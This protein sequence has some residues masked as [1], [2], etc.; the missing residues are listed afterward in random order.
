MTYTYA[1]LKND[2][3]DLNESQ[4]TMPVYIIQNNDE[5]YISGELKFCSLIHSFED[6]Y[7]YHDIPYLKSGEFDNSLNKGER[8]VECEFK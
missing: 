3:S 4:L 8:R 7:D 1:D 2:L 5:A 6:G